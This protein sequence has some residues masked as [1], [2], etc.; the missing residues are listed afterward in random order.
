MSAAPQ[1][2]SDAIAERAYR[3]MR[4]PPAARLNFERMLATDPTLR[5]V[6]WHAMTDDERAECTAYTQRRLDLREVHGPGAETMQARED[7]L[8]WLRRDGPGVKSVDK[9]AWVK[10]YYGRD[11]DTFADFV[12][13]W[14]YTVD[15]RL[16]GDGRNPIVAF[17]LFP[18]QREMI[19]WMVGCWQDGVPGVVVKSRDVGASWVAMALLA[20]LCI[21]RNGFAAGVGSAVEIKIDRSGDPDTLFYKVRSFLE[22]LPVEFNGGFNIDTCSADKRVSFPLTG[23]S[24]TGEAG[25]QAGRGGRKA[26]YIVDESAHFEHPKIIDKNLSANTKC[27]IDMSSVNGMANSFYNR[28]HNPA[29]RRFDFTWRDDPRKNYPGST[30]YEKMQAEL[31][32]VVLKQEIECD[33]AASLEGVCIPSQ[34]VQAAIDL[35]KF[36]GVDM[37]QGAWRAALDIADRGEDKNAFIMTKGRKI[38]FASQ[39]SG[40]GSDTGYSVQRAMKICETHGVPAFDYDADGMGGAAVHSDARLINEARAE[41]QGRMMSK[42]GVTTGEYF[43]AGTIGCNA[44]RGSEAV[45]GPE[46]IV[47]GTQRKAKDLFANRK[48][49]T[50]YEGRLAFFNAWKARNGKP[51][52]ASRLICI[53]GNLANELGRAS[54]RDL[55]VSQLSQ[56]TVK[57]T[58]QGKIQIEKAPE[59]ASSPDLADAAL[60]TLCPRKGLMATGALLAAV[61]APG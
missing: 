18:K 5:R 52:D 25:D 12:N 10:R 58:I 2:T 34:W 35:D 51:Y 36:L 55:L 45:V 28:A 54:L 26:I 4:K 21:Y 20:T 29:I 31:D 40:K 49:Q 32:E 56:A 3:A 27:R 57:E 9:V 33:F 38:K 42:P 23:S 37:E 7:C 44:Y 39:W 17:S 61:S 48:A 16:V 47:P 60:M 13:D 24:I 46:K 50:W 30:W 41:A 22:Y 43:K 6:A 53:D 8:A 14:G 1:I 19:R 11:A 59:G 15:P